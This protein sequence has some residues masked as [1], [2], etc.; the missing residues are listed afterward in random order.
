MKVVYLEQFRRLAAML[1]PENISWDGERSK[2]EIEKARRQILVEWRRLEQEVG[3]PVS[4]SD[5]W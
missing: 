2:S 1:S 3:H 5:I 4:E